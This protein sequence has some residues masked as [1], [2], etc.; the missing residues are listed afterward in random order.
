VSAFPN[1]SASAAART[2][3]CPAWL[4]FPHVDHESEHAARGHVIHR[5]GKAVLSGTAPLQALAAVKDPET[6]ATCAAIDWAKVGG[7]LRDV[8]CEAAYAVDVKARTARFIGVDIG[9]DYERNGPL[10]EWEVP[11]ACDL[12]GNNPDGRPVVDDLK[13][14]FL[15]VE[16]AAYNAQGLMLASAVHL[17]HGA[18]EVEFRISHLKASGK[19]WND[20][21]V[22]TAL[23]V[24]NFLD[25]YEAALVEA[26]EAK[27]VYLAGGTPNVTEGEHCRYCPAANHCPAKARLV[28]A[29]LPELEG[30]DAA[31]ATATPEQAGAAWALAHDR[32]APLL[33]R[34]LDLLKERARRERLPL[35]DGRELRESLSARETLHAESILAL[36][37]KYGATDEEVAECYHEAT[38]RRIIA[39]KPVG[40]RAARKRKVA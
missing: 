23:D 28:R 3:A 33:N 35:P 2:L 20:A 24:D 19:V 8:V 25:D 1:G 37:R 14:G 11:G 36:A 16:P 34:I 9:R 22:H 21:A 15:D 4:A 32:I 38:V 5:Y 17:H 27:H 30:V 12:V 18:A 31:L 7:D 29:M 13:T 10:G 40:E 6:R 39:A 26:R